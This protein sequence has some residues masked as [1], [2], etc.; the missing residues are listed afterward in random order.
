MGTLRSGID[1]PGHARQDLPD[2]GHKGFQDRHDRLKFDGSFSIAEKYIQACLSVL[3]HV[4]PLFSERFNDCH[5]IV[6]DECLSVRD[7]DAAPVLPRPVRTYNYAIA[8]LH[9]SENG[10]KNRVLISDVELVESDKLFAG[11]VWVSANPDKEVS[12]VLSR[13]YYSFDRGFVVDPIGPTDGKGGAFVW[14]AAVDFN[15]FPNGVLQGRPQIV[16]GV[17]YNQAA[18][19]FDVSSKIMVAL[20]PSALYFT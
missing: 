14:C 13:C 6:V 8:Q 1:Q 9:Q 10:I 5:S 17:T 11:P 18:F 15:Q 7:P 12:T 4:K 3:I 16:D 20:V 2:L 19:R